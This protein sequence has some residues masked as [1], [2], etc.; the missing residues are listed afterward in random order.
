MNADATPQVA[1]DLTAGARFA[2]L[3]PIAAGL[4]VGTIVLLGAGVALLVWGASGLGRAVTST[5]DSA[6]AVPAHRTGLAVAEHPYPVQLTGELTAPLSRWL[7]L[8]KWFL[9][10]PH[11]VLLPFLWI[12]FVLTT[13]IACFGILFTGR[14]PRSDLRLQRGRAALDLARRLLHL[15]RVGHRPVPTVQ[16]GPYRLSR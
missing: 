2:L 12:A 15:R 16:P 11:Y 10:I 8:V 6:L 5:G 1:A 14:Y 7:W 9:A 3:G 4:V 13:V